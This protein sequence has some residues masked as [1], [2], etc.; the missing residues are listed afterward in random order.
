M[1]A[2]FLDL[3]NRVKSLLYGMTW[4][5][6]QYTYITSSIGTNDLTF[7]VG[8]ATQISSGLIEIDSEL[9]NVMSI[10]QSA[11]TIT[12]LPGCRGFYGSVPASHANQALIVNNAKF[13]KIRVQDAINDCIN[14][15]FPELFAVGSQEITK[16]AV[17]YEYPMPAAADSVL[18]VDYE[19][20]GPSKIWP[21]MRRW[22]FNPN[23]SNIRGDFPDN[24]SIFLGEEVTPG[25]IIR[26]TY[27]MVPNT[28]VDDTDVFTDVSGLPETAK[29]AV[30]Y[31][32]CAK[33][34]VAYDAA[35]LQMDSI[36][37]SER[38]SM[39]QPTSAAN[40]SKYFMAIYKDRLHVEGQRLRDRYP[41][42]G[43]QTS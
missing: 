26:V 15:V 22:R 38:A 43:T 25:R 17:Q 33:L 10:N 7:G 30:V 12:I 18:Q 11:N 20:I 2:T 3:Q 9:L 36:E 28:L 13:P 37:S 31:G 24:K 16:L 29:D 41:T 8:D 39:T 27:V 34:L 5:Q 1:A 21:S 4:D 32:A 14:E 42:Y 40:T 19:V 6:E 23:A 35:R